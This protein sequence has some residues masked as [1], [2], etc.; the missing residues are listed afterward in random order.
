M[1][2]LS[3]YCFYAALDVLAG[4]QQSTWGHDASCCTALK[5]SEANVQLSCSCVPS[6]KPQGAC[7]RRRREDLSYPLL[8]WQG[9]P[10][11]WPVP[12]GSAGVSVVKM[13]VSSLN[14]VLSP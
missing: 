8:Q 13:H 7:R 2:S 11:C 9:G 4:T 3:Y 12:E 5:R 6:L 14:G 1:L 10:H